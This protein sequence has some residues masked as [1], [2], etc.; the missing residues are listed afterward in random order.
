M[1][2]VPVLILSPAGNAFAQF[3]DV[4][5][6]S[7]STLK[8]GYSVLSSMCDDKSNRT[9]SNFD[10]A[11]GKIL[12]SMADMRSPIDKMGDAVDDQDKS[13]AQGLRDNITSAWKAVA[14]AHQKA[15]DAYDNN[16]DSAEK[17]AGVSD[18]LKNLKTALEAYETA[19]KTAALNYKARWDDLKKDVE[20]Q[21]GNWK[22]ANDK[23][24]SLEQKS[25]DIQKEISSLIAEVDKVEDETRQLDKAAL[26]LFV[27]RGA[28]KD[29]LKQAV[30][31]GKLD[32]I[33][34]AE[35]DLDKTFDLTTRIMDMQ[36]ANGK[37][38]QELNDKWYNK[39]Q[40]L[41]KNEADTHS[42]IT[43]ANKL[44]PYPKI[45]RFSKWDA[46]FPGNSYSFKT[47]R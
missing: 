16:K 3:K 18:E 34:S 8:D 47:L 9:Q 28:I 40:E 42:A 25:E 20:T 15:K 44:L 31:D 26:Q 19:C 14:D 5:E 29:K 35:A 23:V 10:T 36:V 45:Q 24:D 12:S 2:F 37:K 46:E 43:D 13:Y 41:K 22:S 32:D 21:Q 27:Q 39:E 7:W 6:K 1:V 11:L 38:S 4:Q 33:N 17:L 30:K